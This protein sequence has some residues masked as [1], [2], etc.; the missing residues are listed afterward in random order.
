M[1]ELLSLISIH[2][3]KVEGAQRK[4]TQEEENEEFFELLEW[5]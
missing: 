1:G 5:R 3:I 4:L 2:Q